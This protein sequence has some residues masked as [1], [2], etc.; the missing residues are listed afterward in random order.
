MEDWPQV[1]TFTYRMRGMSNKTCHHYMRPYQLSVWNRVSGN[2]NS[3]KDDLC[4][5]S[6]KRHRKSL[7]VMTDFIETYK[8]NSKN[9]LAI[10]HYIENS[11]DGNQRAQQIDGDLVE[12]LRTNW[13]KDNF[14]NTAIFLY[15]DHGVRFGKERN[16]PQGYLEER[17]PFFSIYLPPEYRNANPGK[18]KSLKKNAQQLT[19]PFDIH[20]TIRDVTCL[21][22]KRL[23]RAMSVLGEIP[24]ERT[25]AQMGISLHYCVSGI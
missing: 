23:K 11:H 13:R 25:C 9:H 7:D 22:S 16:A 1:T 24:I 17:Q 19:S 14:K 3:G 18:M 8:D 10:M 20:E 2:Y 12:F 4:I 6:V 5:G 15:S 21:A